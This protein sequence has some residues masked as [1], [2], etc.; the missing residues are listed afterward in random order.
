MRRFPRFLLRR[1]GVASLE[2]MVVLISLVAVISIAVPV[3]LSRFPLSRNT[4]TQKRLEAIKEAITGSRF[5]MGNRAQTTFGFVG[6]LGVL[7]DALTDP[8]WPLVDLLENRGNKYPASATSNNVTSGWRGPYLSIPQ[9]GNPYLS[10][11][12]AWGRVIRINTVSGVDP[13]NGRTRLREL[14]SDGQDPAVGATADDLTLL[15]YADEVSNFVNGDFLNAV[16]HAVLTGYSGTLRIWYPNGSAGLTSSDFPISA[17]EYNTQ[18]GAAIR[19]PVGVRYFETSDGTYQKIAA[20]NAG[21]ENGINFFGEDATASGLFFERTFY[22]TDDVDAASGSPIREVMGNWEPD[23]GDPVSG[24]YAPVGSGEHRAVFGNPTLW[25]DYRIEVDATLWWGR[26]Y[27]IYYRASGQANITGYCL[28]YDP[29]LNT[30]GYAMTFVVREVVNGAEQAPFQRRNLTAAQWPNVFNTPHHISI[31]VQGDHHIIKADGAVIFD[32]YDNTFMTGAGGLRSWDAQSSVYFH[33]IQAYDIPPLPSGE[34]AWW[35]FEEGPGDNEAYGSGFLIGATELNGTLA[36]SW[37]VTREWRAGNV[38]GRAL[39]FSGSATGYFNF[40]DILDYTP[41]HSFTIVFWLNM[42]YLNT[43]EH[44]SLLSKIHQG[45][46]RGW[47]VDLEPRGADG[48]CIQFTFQQTQ[49][50]QRMQVYN[51]RGL[52][53]NRWYQVAVVYN[54]AGL[55]PGESVPPESV[56]IYVTPATA[57]MVGAQTLNFVVNSL[58]QSSSTTHD[59]NMLLGL[60]PVDNFRPFLA[61]F[62]ELRIYGRALTY[63]EIN[64]LFLRFR[65]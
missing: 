47:A 24:Y 12:D 51:R 62:D 2:L 4:V 7:P 17:G 63:S 14:R 52:S 19:I 64:N 34:T 54:G 48:F 25:R 46:R 9:G 40:G 53:I 30:S 57:M 44:Y 50:T 28:Q 13:A 5:K 10:I 35:S 56:S 29:G 58:Y 22:A 15:I 27:G 23:D 38:Y 42:E 49:N 8:A 45:N 61:L 55:A 26:G 32:F 1:R 20:I 18:P 3:F 33:H 59:A 43:S 65:P 60:R 36:A 41:A 11:I 37:Q 31:T 21:G 6:D 16:T 39:Y